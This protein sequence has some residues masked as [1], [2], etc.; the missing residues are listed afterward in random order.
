MRLL[1]QRRPDRR[2]APR[3]RHHKVGVDSSV[4]LFNPS[5]QPH[6]VVDV[7]GWFGAESNDLPM[8]GSRTLDTSGE[9]AVG[10]LA[11]AASVLGPE[12][13]ST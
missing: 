4:S 7:Q 8:V 5:A 3:T 2:V 12:K 13:R 1:P 9:S 11:V 10:V 6:V